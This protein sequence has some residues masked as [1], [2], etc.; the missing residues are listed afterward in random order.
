MAS[1]LIQFAFVLASGIIHIMPN[2]VGAV[3]LQFEDTSLK[4][5]ALQTIVESFIRGNFTPTSLEERP[6]RDQPYFIR[7]SARS[8][9]LRSGYYFKP[10]YRFMRGPRAVKANRLRRRYLPARVISG[11]LRDRS[12][13]VLQWAL[14]DALHLDGDETTVIFR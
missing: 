10:R 5:Y 8:K 2:E 11:P 14:T 13:V 3:H 7:R 1:G 12:N 4:D 9:R 6:C